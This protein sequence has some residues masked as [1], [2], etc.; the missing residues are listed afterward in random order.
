[1]QAKVSKK[2]GG[3]IGISIVVDADVVGICSGI[4]VVQDIAN[5]LKAVGIISVKCKSC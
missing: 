4:C 5:G 1:M 2:G 3:P